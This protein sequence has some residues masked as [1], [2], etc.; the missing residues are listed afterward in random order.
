MDVQVGIL[1][2]TCEHVYRELYSQTKGYENVSSASY[3][4]AYPRSGRHGDGVVWC[5]AELELQSLEGTST[6]FFL[7]PDPRERAT[8]LG[9]A[10]G[11]TSPP[12][13]LLSSL[14]YMTLHTTRH[15]MP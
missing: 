4:Y 15:H 7:H 12:R 5:A 2:F 14:V 13:I 10:A 9:Y 8:V 1:R 11:S 3:G 6:E